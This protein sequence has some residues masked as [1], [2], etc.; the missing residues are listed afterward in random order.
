MENVPDL[1]NPVLL[2]GFDPVGYFSPIVFAGRLFYGM[3][4]DALPDGKK[5]QGEKTGVVFLDQHVMKSFFQ[6]IH[7][8][9]VT[10]QVISAF[11][12]SLPERT[13]QRLFLGKCIH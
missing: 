11:V 10:V 12:T 5:I 9:T 1:L 13:K 3:P 8:I 2:P 7:A 4:A 6:D